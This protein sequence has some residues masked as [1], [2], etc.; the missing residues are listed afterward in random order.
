MNPGSRGSAIIHVTYGLNGFISG[1][2]LCH[3]R[4]SS[5][6]SNYADH[7]SPELLRSV[8]AKVGQVCRT[9]ALS[10]RNICTHKHLD[11]KSIAVPITLAGCLNGRVSGSRA[12]AESVIMLSSRG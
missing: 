2:G 12:I 5:E 4:S 7:F 9:H 6:A 11:D 1:C 8:P 10:Q 3:E